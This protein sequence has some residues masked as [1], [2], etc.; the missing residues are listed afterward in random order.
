MN[1]SWLLLTHQL[2]SEPSN[3]RVKVWRKLQ[4]LG[5]VPIKN[6][7]YALPNDKETR[8]DFEWLRKEILQMKGEASIFL[9]DSLDP[10][11]ERAIVRTFQQAR[12]K[13]FDALLVRGAKLAEA[14]K[15]TLEGGHVKTESL[16]RLD[17]EWS[18]LKLERDRL[19]GLDFFKAPNRGKADGLMASLEKLLRRARSLC[20]TAVP[21]E[22]PPV[23]PA[24]LKRRVWVTRKSPHIDRLASAWLIR[25]FVDPSARF[26]F[27]AEPY[28]RKDGEV[29]FDMYEGEFTHFG[30]WCTF[31]TLLHQLGLKD[32]AV[33]RIG[34][35][36]HDLDLKDG[37]F[38]RPEAAGLGLAVAGLCRRH[39]NDSER[40]EAG[41]SF[42]DH[43]FEGLRPGKP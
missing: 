31:E 20:A 40:L 12:A 24:G 39:G 38:G 2:P 33:S 18:A 15:G 43:V 26:K 13:D 10:A 3:T 19:I 1:C 25:R 42:F 41:L 30:D 35:I 27:V 4:A 8:E 11:E 14:V 17:K 34:E 22:L 6:S 32:P 29:R 36:V 9:A 28:R 21:P 23:D 16:E 7:I 5:A 37:K